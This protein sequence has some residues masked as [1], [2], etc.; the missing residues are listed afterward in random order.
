MEEKLAVLI[1][2][3]YMKL[4]LFFLLDFTVV[5]L[6]YYFLFVR[7]ARRNKK[8]PQEAQYLINLYKLDIK[9]FSYKK[10][11][12]HVSLVS[13]FDVALV[14]LL[15]T[16]ISGLVWQLLFGLIIVIPVAVISFMLLGKYYKEKQERDNTEELEKE[17]KYLDKIDNKKNKSKKTK[18]KEEVKED[19]KK[20]GQK[21]NVK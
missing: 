16:N 18:T 7:N 4:L 20:K 13:S 11:L 5:F 15:V 19:T 10:F 14:V 21:K 3:Y 12:L 2:R 1:W 6:L 8:G 9:K 17:Q